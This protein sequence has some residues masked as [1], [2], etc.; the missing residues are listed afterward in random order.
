MRLTFA[1]LSGQNSPIIVPIL[2]VQTTICVTLL[3]ASLPFSSGQFANGLTIAAVIKGINPELSDA[4]A[5]ASATVNGPGIIIVNQPLI[6]ISTISLYQSLN[7]KP[8]FMA[9]QP[10]NRTTHLHLVPAPRTDNKSASVCNARAKDAHPIKASDFRQIRPY[11]QL[12]LLIL[13]QSCP[14][15]GVSASLA[16]RYGPIVL[17]GRTCASVIGGALTV[18]GLC[19]RFLGMTSL[20]FLPR[21]V[22]GLC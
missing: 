18:F 12:R 21:P 6:C 10:I 16:L 3:S 15:E 8:V 7:M 20:R 5:A 1:Y 9:D 19:R 4:L 13:L 22:M 11:T 2:N 14:G 17:D